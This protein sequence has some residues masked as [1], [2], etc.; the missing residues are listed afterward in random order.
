[1]KV[2]MIQTSLWSRQAEHRNG[3]CSGEGRVVA[4]DPLASE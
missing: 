3:M 1:M 2:G 4:E